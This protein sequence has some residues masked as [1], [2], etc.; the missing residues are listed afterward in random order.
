MYELGAFFAEDPVEVEI[1]DAEH[2]ADFAGTIVCHARAA[3]SDAAICQIDLVAVSPGAALV[4]FGAFDIH[5][6]AGKVILNKAGDRA[7]GYESRQ[8]LNGKSE[9]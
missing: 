5:V 6:P 2:A 9:V 7:A 1:L 8:D 3:G 4:E